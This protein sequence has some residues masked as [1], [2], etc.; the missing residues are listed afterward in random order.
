MAAFSLTAALVLGA[1]DAGRTVAVTEDN[2]L[3]IAGYTDLA[4]DGNYDFLV[5]KLSFER[6]LL[7]YKTFGGLESDKAY[8]ITSVVDAA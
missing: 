6:D 7:W 5:M 3:M 4:G 1:D 8:T 2:C